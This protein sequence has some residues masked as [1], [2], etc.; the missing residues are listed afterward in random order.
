MELRGRS[1]CPAGIGSTRTT[2]VA[3]HSRSRSIRLRSISA[4]ATAAAG[5]PHSLRS[6][7]WVT[8]WAW[9]V[10]WCQ[11]ATR[12]LSSRRS[13]A[14][15]SWVVSSG[16][17]G[18]GAGR[19]LRCG[20]LALALGQQLAHLVGLEQAR[21]A[22]EVHLLL[23]ADVHLPSWP[24]SAPSK[25]TRSKWACEPSASNGSSAARRRRDSPAWACASRSFSAA[26]MSSSSVIRRPSTW[27]RCDLELGGVGQQVSAT[28]GRNTDA[29]SPRPRARTKRPTAWA[30]NSGVEVVVA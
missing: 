2:W 5:P 21:D 16:T 22:E 8:P 24:N 6:A 13:T 29:V 30:K 14:S 1:D 4:L 7:A 11:A 28:D 26:K 18:S 17:S 25:S 15:C 27:S 19:L 3:A 9:P 23:G 20:A 12:P 10:R